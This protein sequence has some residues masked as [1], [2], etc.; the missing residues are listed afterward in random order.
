MN[1]DKMLLTAILTRLQNLSH[2]HYFYMYLFMLVY[3]GVNL[4]FYAIL[5]HIYIHE[6]TSPIKIQIRPGTSGSH[7]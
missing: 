1:I 4:W 3:V 5:S 6:T 2:F 7:L